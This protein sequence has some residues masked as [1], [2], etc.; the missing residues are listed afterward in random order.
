MTYG[1]PLNAIV[2]KLHH[3][4]K[5]IC[6]INFYVIT[7]KVMVGSLHLTFMFVIYSLN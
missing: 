1:A 3:T 7:H 5:T 4:A 2:E 6:I